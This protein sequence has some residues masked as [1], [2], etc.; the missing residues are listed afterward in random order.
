MKKIYMFTLPLIA[1][2]ILSFGLA[3]AR[4]PSYDKNEIIPITAICDN[5]S[6]VNL[7]KITYPNNDILFLNILMNKT[8]TNYYTTFNN[9]NQIGI[10]NYITCGDLNGIVTCDDTERSFQI[11]DKKNLLSFDLT[12]NL[13]IVLLVFMFL[14]AGLMLLLGYR[15]FSGIILLILGFIILGLNTLFG[16]IIIVTG[17]IIGISKGEK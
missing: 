1:I 2:L 15:L 3:S 10:Y 17:I 7:T 6:Q 4:I 9:T 5:C 14:L 8:G 16:F 13:A 12:S 11:L